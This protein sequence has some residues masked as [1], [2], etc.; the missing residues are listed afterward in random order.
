[1]H[2]IASPKK[3]NSGNFSCTWKLLASVN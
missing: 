2:A 1:M 3:E